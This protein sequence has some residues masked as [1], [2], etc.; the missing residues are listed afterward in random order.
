M[1]SLNCS[2]V[3]ILKCTSVIL[4]F[5]GLPTLLL[6]ITLQRYIGPAL[7]ENTKMFTTNCLFPS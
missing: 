4:V 3:H 1:L 2:L 5:L 7:Q 6:V